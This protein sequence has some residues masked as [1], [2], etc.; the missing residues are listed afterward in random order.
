MWRVTWRDI[1]VETLVKA[2][3]KVLFSSVL[4]S[5]CGCN[6]FVAD[7]LYLKFCGVNLA[8]MWFLLQETKTAFGR[9]VH[10]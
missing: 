4:W 5:L 1:S 6:V 8:V 9:E 3:K 2:F 7:P 10:S